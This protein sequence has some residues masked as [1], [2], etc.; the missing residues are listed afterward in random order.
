MQ[1]TVHRRHAAWAAYREHDDDMQPVPKIIAI[2]IRLA[3]SG[4][5]KPSENV[6]L[7]DLTPMLRDPAFIQRAPK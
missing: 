1:H 5:A 2:L 6:L 4:A 3:A 7:Q